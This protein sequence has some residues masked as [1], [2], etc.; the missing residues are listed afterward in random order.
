MLTQEYVFVLENFYLLHKLKKL[1]Q[2]YHLPVIYLFVTYMN[3]CLGKPNDPG[4][5]ISPSLID[6]QL[7]RLFQIVLV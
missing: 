2:P 3:T 6:T 7:V 1:G 4:L 5:F